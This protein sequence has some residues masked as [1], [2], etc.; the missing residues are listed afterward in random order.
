MKK[1]RNLLAASAF[2]ALAGCANYAANLQTFTNNVVATNDAIAQISASLAQNCDALHSAAEGLAS[3]TS[4]LDLTPRGSKAR[5]GLAAANAALSSWCSAPPNDIGSAL[6]AT[7]AEI[8]AA[9][10]AYK[11]ALAQ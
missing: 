1:F 9:K 10:A 3:L 6:T 4:S 8:Q 11:E 7:A 5:A 2:V